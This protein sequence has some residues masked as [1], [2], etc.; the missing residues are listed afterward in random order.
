M[1]AFQ[2]SVSVCVRFIALGLTD[3]YS[4]V[5]QILSKPSKVEF[6]H[7]VSTET[8]AFVRRHIHNVK[9]Y[10]FIL[11]PQALTTNQKWSH[12]SK[13]LRQ[14]PHHI[15]KRTNRLF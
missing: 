6:P 14:L 7:V 5:N 3:F 4:I 9:Q 12:I 8:W 1:A 13:H 2:E 11:K 10:I 15:D